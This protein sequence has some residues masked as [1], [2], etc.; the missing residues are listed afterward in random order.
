VSRPVTPPARRVFSTINFFSRYDLFIYIH[1]FE[2]VLKRPNNSHCDQ[3][4][5]WLVLPYSF[6][7]WT[8]QCDCFFPFLLIA[9]GSQNSTPLF[10]FINPPACFRPR[11]RQRVCFYAIRD[12]GSEV[13]VRGPSLSPWSEWLVLSA[14]FSFIYQNPHNVLPSITI[15]FQAT[16]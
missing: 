12:N 4:F 11:G 1:K 14:S 6:P 3:S 9:C 13:A 8:L 15:F 10:F 7:L 5:W 16:P 2:G